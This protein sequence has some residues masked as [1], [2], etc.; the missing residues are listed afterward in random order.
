MNKTSRKTIM[1]RSRLENIFIRKRN[2]KNMETY[3]KQRK[4]CADLLRKTK[5]EFFKNLNQKH[6]EVFLG[7][8]V[9]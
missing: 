9:L 4:F 3:K 8:G 2:Y 7:K 1:H 5:T 6:P